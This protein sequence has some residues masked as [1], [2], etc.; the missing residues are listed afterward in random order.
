MSKNKLLLGSHVGFKAK[1][2]LVGSV[3]ETLEYDGNCFMVFTGPP[4]NFMRKELDQNLIDEAVKLMKEKNPLLLENI[5][6]HAP[7]LINLGSPKESTRSLG[8]NQLIVEIN[9]TNQ[10]HSK[11]IVLHPGSALDSDRNVAINHIADNLNKAIEATDNDVIICVETMAGKGSE[12]GINFEEVS[13]I[14]SGVKNKK[15]IGVC[16]DTC[17]MH[18]SGIDISDPD[19]TL[20]EF[21]KY[22]DLS[23]IKVI[24]LNDSKNEIGSRKDR[25]DNIGY[26]K[27][28]FDYLVKWAHNEKLANVPKILETPYRDDKPI[29]KQE[30]INLNSKEW[31]E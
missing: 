18:D 25:H 15:R 11:L 24:H 13:K 4:Q 2:Y 17:H 19:Q 7:Y 10:I 22:L 3:L 28:G 23:Y 27:V 26:G 29:Y 9:R 5:V 12:V 16:L 6:V 30:I 21:S 8:L 1:N 31:K 14:V 20:E